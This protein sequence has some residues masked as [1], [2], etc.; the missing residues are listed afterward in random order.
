[1]NAFDNTNLKTGVC[2][3][4]DCSGFV[5]SVTFTYNSGAKTITVTDAT[6]Y[7]ATDDRKIVNLRVCDKNWKTV[8][9]NIAA[10]DGDDAVTLDVSSLD[11]SEGFVLNATVLS[12]GGCI[13]DGHYGRLGMVATAGT[14]S[15]WDMD[16]NNLVISDVDADDES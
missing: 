11:L 1:M 16:N 8:D 12:N 5:P 2:G 9:G 3:G 10:A 6:T 15:S 13:S 14:L 4:C 7:P